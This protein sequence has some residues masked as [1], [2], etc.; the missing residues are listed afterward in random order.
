MCNGQYSLGLDHAVVKVVSITVN[1]AKEGLHSLKIVSNP[2]A[3]TIRCKE[4]SLAAFY[5]M[6][7]PPPH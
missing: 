5:Y 4:G 2:S 1:T 7:L 6:Y 3:R